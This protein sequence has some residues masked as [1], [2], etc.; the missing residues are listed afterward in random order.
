MYTCDQALE[1][2]SARLDGAL[3]PEEEAGLEEH[4]AHCPD[5][6][7]LAADLEELHD[8]MPGLY[9]EPPPELK[10]RVM[11]QIR[12]ESAPISLDE[13]R[14]KRS[15]RKTWRSWGAMAAV[16]A[17]VFM[18][19]LA[20]RFGGGDTAG[21]PENAPVQS[22]SLYSA[23]PEASE[24]AEADAPMS[25]EAEAG[26][27]TQS[28]PSGD[29]EGDVQPAQDEPQ[30]D[31]SGVQTYTSEGTAKTAAEGQENQ[32]EPSEG[33]ES[34]TETAS[35]TPFRAAEP[36]ENEP[37]NNNGAAVPNEATLMEGA[38]IDSTQPQPA[39]K[40]YYASLPEGW[41]KFFPDVAGIDA[42]RV[43]GEDA[44]AFLELLKE[45]DIPYA[46]EGDLSGENGDVQLLSGLPE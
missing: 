25:R 30:A 31:G 13:V 16:M 1:L 46:V 39:G 26:D 21:I 45:Q 22:A 8:A 5:C 37:E 7:A 23:L 34:Q 2:L 38:G 42:M 29:T 32:A 44:Q 19:A 10:E 24:P 12:A 3:T 17:V 20:M 4:L 28:A 40:V 33:Q 6:R 43:S 36:G 14:K 35:V 15:G 18:S 11:A 27:S 41:E 9:Q